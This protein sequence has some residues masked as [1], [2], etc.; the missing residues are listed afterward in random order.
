MHHGVYKLFIPL[1][2]P[3]NFIFGMNRMDDIMVLFY[4]HLR[5]DYSQ[6]QNFQELSGKFA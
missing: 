1:F 2:S 4:G 5:G 6:I 3:D